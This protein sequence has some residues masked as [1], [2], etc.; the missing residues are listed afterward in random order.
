[1]AGPVEACIAEVRERLARVE[2]GLEGVN[3]RLDLLIELRPALTPP[4]PPPP[5]PEARPAMGGAV[6]GAAGAGIGL[7]LV[8]GL[9]RWLFS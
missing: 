8:E 6:V 4:P 9:R 3:G 1:M 5:P 7:G 2:E